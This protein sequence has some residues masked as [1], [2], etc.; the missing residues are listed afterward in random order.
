MITS[1]AL[2][3]ACFMTPF[4]LAFEWLDHHDN[5]SYQIFFFTDTWNSL[6]SI[7]DIIFM[8]EIIVCFNTSYYYEDDD[9]KELKPETNGLEDGL[10][11]RNKARDGEQYLNLETNRCK[12]AKKY[13]CGWFWVDFLA[14][15]PRFFRPFENN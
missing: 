3:I 9:N 13:L 7:I 5:N 1:L 10:D 4:G 14:I 6:D 2:I 8:L 12:I 15:L 11:N